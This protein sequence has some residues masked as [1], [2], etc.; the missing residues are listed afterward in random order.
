MLWL[1]VSFS[2]ERWKGGPSQDGKVI[3]SGLPGGGANQMCFTAG[4]PSR[5]VPGHQADPCL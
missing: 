1:Y 2:P 3:D 5:V 4:Q